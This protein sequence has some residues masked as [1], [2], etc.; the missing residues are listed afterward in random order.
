MAVKSDLR[1]LG[2]G[3]SLAEFQSA[4][5]L[6]NG[7]SQVMLMTS[8]TAATAFWMKRGYQVDHTKFLHQIDV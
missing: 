6:K 4:E 1:G 3:A 2:I 5:A 8:N 7:H